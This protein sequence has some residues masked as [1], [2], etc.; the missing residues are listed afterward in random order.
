MSKTERYRG[1]TYLADFN[2][3][4]STGKSYNNDKKKI[5]I[6]PIQRLIF[7]VGFRSGNNSGYNVDILFRSSIILFT[8]KACF[9]RVI[10]FT[11]KA[12]IN[13]YQRPESQ[14]YDLVLLC[15]LRTTYR[16]AV[17][18]RG[19]CVLTFCW[20]LSKPKV[21]KTVIQPVC[22]QVWHVLNSMLESIVVFVYMQL[23]SL[24]KLVVAIYLSETGTWCTLCWR[25]MMLL[26]FS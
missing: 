11:I 10:V 6:K 19:I 23:F 25:L 8:I 7:T 13:P 17:Y 24:F 15:F 4:R 5:K 22:V 18:T 16:Y 20:Y 1:F 14:Y 21:F 9:A 26:S 2:S 12:Y 3:R